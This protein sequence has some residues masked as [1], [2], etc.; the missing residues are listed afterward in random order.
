MVSRFEG[1]VVMIT[2]AGSPIGAAT[3]RR[4]H[5]EGATVI[6]CGRKEE[7]L[8]KIAS[9]LNSE[10]CLVQTADLTVDK[11]VASLVSDTALRFRRIDVLVNNAGTAS[12]GDFLTQTRL[13][14]NAIM[15]LMV[16]AKK[17]AF[18]SV[19]TL[20]SLDGWGLT[21]Y[22]AALS[23]LTSITR[24]MATEF[25]PKGIRVNAVCP[26]ITG[27]ELDALNMEQIP[28]T[29]RGQFENIPLGRGAHPQEIA[30]AIAF[31]ASD[32][33]SVINGINLPVD[34]GLSALF[35]FSL[36]NR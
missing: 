33:A 32:E 13:L 8:A 7:E 2:R 34:G 36:F 28:R 4:F 29:L 16:S 27:A 23:V 1:R 14:S 5:A 26:S 18:I 21:F 15:P 12:T 9:G 10:R 31:L 11:E 22:H 17:G 3:A 25:G 19:T 24:S 20:G 35:E 30:S 6:L